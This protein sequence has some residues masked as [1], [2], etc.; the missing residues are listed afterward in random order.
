MAGGR[1][2]RRVVGFRGPR[3]SAQVGGALLAEA[4][5][6]RADAIET[7]L[8][9][10]FAVELSAADLILLRILQIFHFEAALHE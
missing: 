5:L 9:L 10:V 4:H 2:A 7:G 1:R 3:R 8:G 6:E